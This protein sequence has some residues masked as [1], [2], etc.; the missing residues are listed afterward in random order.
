MYTN[1]FV[2]GADVGR[3]LILGKKHSILHMI[4][5]SSRLKLFSLS[6]FLYDKT[7]NRDSLVSE[8]EGKSGTFPF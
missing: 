3:I 2:I 8:G 7:L 4:C 6:L 1:E 5:P